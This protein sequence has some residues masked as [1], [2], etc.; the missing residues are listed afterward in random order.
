MLEY[1]LRSAFDAARRDI[2]VRAFTFLVWKIHSSSLLL[3]RCEYNEA[4]A[5]SRKSPYFPILEAAFMPQV[6][7]TAHIE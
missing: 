3:R 1:N 5:S 2:K 7:T 6:S 4:G